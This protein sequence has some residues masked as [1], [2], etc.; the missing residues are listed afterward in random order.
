M[1]GRH[2]E[3]LPDRR[4]AEAAA[5]AARARSAPP[6]P[7]RRAR[8]R[9]SASPPSSPTNDLVTENAMCWRSGVEHAEVALVDDPAAVQDD[10]AVGVVGVE[11]LRPGH[12]VGAA[13]RLKRHGI[14]VARARH[15]AAPPPRR[16]R[17]TTR[18][19]GTSS[20][21][22][23]KAHRVCGNVRKL[24]S[25]NATIL[26]AGGGDPAIHPSATGS[27][28][29]ASGK[30]GAWLCDQTTHPDR[31]TAAASTASA[32]TRIVLQGGSEDPQLRD[33]HPDSR[34]SGARSGSAHR[35]RASGDMQALARVEREE[36]IALDQRTREQPIH[37][38]RERQPRGLASR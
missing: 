14:E 1:P 18:L 30:T 9:R 24:P 37:P 28:A 2:V 25:A 32:R 8:P 22:C 38:R 17:A 34:R 19:V 3:Q 13:Q 33:R 29:R 15:A 26:S 31:R 27:V 11:R 5:L 6:W 21:M 4:V 35:A 20:R 10:D 36:H 7:A 16:C 23:E 12:R